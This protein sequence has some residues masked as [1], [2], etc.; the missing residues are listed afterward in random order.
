MAQSVKC[1]HGGYGSLSL[2]SP[3]LWKHQTQ[4]FESAERQEQGDPSL[5]CELQVQGNPHLK[6]KWGVSAEGT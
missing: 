2:D 6:N 3:A 5:I 1:S 4:Q